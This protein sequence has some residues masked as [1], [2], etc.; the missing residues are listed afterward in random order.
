[1]IKFQNFHLD[2]KW[3]MIKFQPR[4]CPCLYFIITLI[5]LQ[6]SSNATSFGKE[7]QV[8]ACHARGKGAMSTAK[9]ASSQ[10]NGTISHDLSVP[11]DQIS[12]CKFYFWMIT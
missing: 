8:I 3:H 5:K 12:F 11:W 7:W 6:N 10:R 4:K 2:W 9:K 1:M